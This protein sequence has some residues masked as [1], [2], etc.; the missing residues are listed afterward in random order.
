MLKLLNRQVAQHIDLPMGFVYI[1]QSFVFGGGLL[2]IWYGILSARC[3]CRN[4]A[5]G[6]AEWTYMVRVIPVCSGMPN[7]HGTRVCLF[8]DCLR[9]S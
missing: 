8:I 4:Y 9:C 7:D 3:A 5:V 6:P 1:T 2:G